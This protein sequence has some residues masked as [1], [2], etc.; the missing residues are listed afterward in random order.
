MPILIQD[1]NSNGSIFYIGIEQQ[2]PF[3]VNHKR[4]T[5]LES[6]NPLEDLE[7]IKEA[8]PDN[9]RNGDFYAFYSCLDNVK[10]QIERI[11]T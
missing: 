10:K 11:I 1:C 7:K 8:F 4:E 5:F 9:I 6:N 2:K 3:F